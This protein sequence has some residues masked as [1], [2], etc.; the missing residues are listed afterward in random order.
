VRKEGLQLRATAS[1]SCTSFCHV[2]Q[3]R[4]S[5]GHN[6]QQSQRAACSSRQRTSLARAESGCAVAGDGARSSG[7]GGREVVLCNHAGCYL[8]NGAVIIW[9]GDQPWDRQREMGWAESTQYPQYR[10]L[11]CYAQ[12]QPHIRLRACRASCNLRTWP[13]TCHIHGILAHWGLCMYY[14]QPVWTTYLL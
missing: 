5:L 10:V 6:G 12:E 11:R 2:I 7:S 13:C 4:C 14:G 3:T 1:G 9:R 8:G